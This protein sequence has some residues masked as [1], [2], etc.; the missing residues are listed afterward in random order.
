MKNTFK[1]APMFVPY[2]GPVYIGLGIAN[3]LAK[4]LPIIYKTTFG[5]AGASTDWANK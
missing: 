2:V 3:E 5:L 1:I 4:V